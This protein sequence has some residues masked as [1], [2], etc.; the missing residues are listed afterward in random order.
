MRYSSSSLNTVIVVVV[1]CQLFNFFISI[2]G[3]VKSIRGRNGGYLYDKDPTSI[4][5][6][7]IMQA[8]DEVLDARKCNGASSCHNGKKCSTHD[9]WHELNGIVEN[10]LDKITIDSLVENDNSPYI[11]VKEIN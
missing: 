7:E 5:V 2:A 10:Y 4:T 9:L 8:V 1:V 6:K 11:R 3:I